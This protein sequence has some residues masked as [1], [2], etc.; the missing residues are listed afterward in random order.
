MNDVIR[1]EDAQVQRELDRDIFR[2]R[3]EGHSSREIAEQFGLTGDD[4]R[5]AMKRMVVGM[6][7]RYRADLVELES[8]RLDAMMTGIFQSAQLGNVTHIET[9]LKIMDRRAKLL[10]LDAPVKTTHA[11][12]AEKSADTG[13]ISSSD[14]LLDRLKKLRNEGTVIEGE[15][16]DVTPAP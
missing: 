1:Y 9:V 13:Q 2:L 10:G 14:R 5:A 7:P 12:D 8:E 15:V 16:L 3:M 6:S 4:I 11:A